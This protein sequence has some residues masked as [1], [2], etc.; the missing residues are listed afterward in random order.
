LIVQP[1]A[2]RS[3]CVN[4]SMVI[5]DN[6]SASNTMS[7]PSH[8]QILDVNLQ[9]DV[10]H[11]RIG[12]LSFTLEHNAASVIP[13]DRPGYSGAG[14]G[15]LGN[16]LPNIVLD[17]DPGGTPGTPVETSCQNATPAYTP[18]G[19]YTPN[20]PLSVLAGG[21]ING[22]WTITAHDHASGSTG[23]MNSWC[24]AVTYVNDPPR[25]V[26]DSN[27][28]IE[29]VR[30]SVAAPGVLGNDTDAD[31]DPLTSELVSGP[32]H[33]TL[34]FNP[35][36]SFV[37]TPILH[38]N[39][40]DSFTYIANDGWADS[41][42]GKVYID[43]TPA[44]DPDLVLT[45][46]DYPDP[47]IYGQPLLYILNVTNVGDMS[48]T[49]VVVTDTLPDGVTFISATTDLGICSGDEG[50][51][52]C[53]QP[54]NLLVNPGAET[55][56]LSGWN[57]IENGGDDWSATTIMPHQGGW[58][59][60]TSFNST[61]WDTRYQEIDLLA[62]GYTAS[63]LNSAPQVAVGEWIRG[64]DCGGACN[65]N[66]PFYIRV[67]L[68]DVSHNPIASW[69]IGS[70]YSPAFATATWTEHAHTFASY[71]SGLRYIY[72]EDGGTD[73]ESWA[74]HY[75]AQMDD[76]YVN[77]GP[78][79]I[80][81]GAEYGI[82]I[83]TSVDAY[84]QLINTAEVVS[85]EID[86]HPADN[87]AT[88]TTNVVPPLV[89]INKSVSPNTQV[90]FHGVVT[91]TAVLA[92]LS[93]S[94]DIGVSLQDI[95]PEEVDFDTWLE[96]PTG[97]TVLN[98]VVTW[99]GSIAGQSTIT[100]SFTALHVGNYQDVVVNTAS[101]DGSLQNGSDLAV[102]VVEPNYPPVLDPIGGR[103]M[104]ELTTTQFT[105]M[106]MD[107][108]RNG[109]LVYSL[110]AG[111]PAGAGIDPITGAF[112]WTPTEEQGPGEYTITVRVTD[113]G[114][115]SDSEIISIA[116][117][118]V[119]VA[120]VLATIGSQNGNE[121]APITFDANADD[122]DLPA[123]TLTFSLEVGAPAGASIDPISG[124]F[125]W[126][127]DESQGPGVYT[128]TVR[129]VDNG[130]P[131]LYDFETIEIT[132]GEVNA[133]PIVAA[134]VYTI[135]EDTALEVAAPGLLG[136][137]T[138]LDLPIQA[139]YAVL[140]TPPAYGELDLAVDGSF[141][142][143][144][145]LNYYGVVTCTYYANDGVDHSVLALVTISVV[146]V[147]DNPQV[148]AGADQTAGEGQLVQFTGSYT[149][150]NRLVDQAATI[151]WSFGDGST[152]SGTLTPTH[153][154]ADD[155]LYYVMLEVDDGEGGIASDT[156]LVTV[157]NVAPDLA[158]IGDQSTNAGAILSIT[159]TYTDPG[160]LDAQ[161]VQIDWGDG[162]AD[163]L[164]LEAGLASF[165]MAHAFADIGVYAVTITLT[166]DGGESDTV[167]F[168]VTVEGAGYTV[169]LPYVA[170]NPGGTP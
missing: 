37:Y 44:P 18:G 71:G 84:G 165:N 163:T 72:F 151:T 111:A 127:T 87:A 5:P 60:I 126:M 149:D 115:L 68:R 153:T 114:G 15:C 135:S 104:D 100:F 138:D 101:F 88:T 67:E 57:I 167:R 28:I 95:L 74:G 58:S 128:V 27:T 77:V 1:Y 38:Y 3:F 82:T 120:P 131:T 22:S 99:N 112:A 35:D 24:L 55:G 59:F 155:G 8:G 73:A 96:Q 51:L 79:G 63:F 7:I 152:A 42:V 123:N 147:N 143:T 43:I 91:Y 36:G 14:Y 75:G 148:E 158:S 13:I 146:S 10:T 154:Y 125:T 30:F 169:W 103:T 16:N 133:A 46:S 12:D 6:G 156:L 54:G 80:D 4:P 85:N 49:G 98:D 162:S 48:A 53:Y 161:V 50:V 62:A 118:E 41:N 113:D 157:S 19:S 70:R 166:D 139:L 33:G 145:T 136:N 129:V 97:A 69:H 65:P 109:N 124:V 92:N 23:V 52:S 141:V 20:N 81:P 116:V 122:V 83:L 108:N 94:P 31:G 107:G 137:D 56:D 105:A 168:L 11:P 150:P 9:L 64:M 106:A 93:P 89:S 130:M 102:F 140:V 34:D 117:A 26:D 170:R 132:V 39:G 110:D 90:T 17:N 2:I 142:Y 86:L 66:D 76:A 29:D 32:S 21:D 47:V 159:A 121:L 144:P 134:D 119:N 40:Q 160:L 164:I 45:K 25:A 61:L 78:T